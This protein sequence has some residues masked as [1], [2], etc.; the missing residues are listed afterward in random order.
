MDPNKNNNGDAVL[1]YGEQMLVKLLDQIW[2]VLLA[3]TLLAGTAS[4]FR[5]TST[6]WQPIYSLHIAL[7]IFYCGCFSLRKHLS[8]DVRVGIL[9]TLFYIVGISGVFSF[10]LVG[11]GAWWLVLCALIA[12]IFYSYRAGLIHAAISLVLIAVAGYAYTTGLLSIPFDANEY[13]TRVSTW[14]TLFFGCVFMSLFIFSAITTYQRALFSLLREFVHSKKE[15]EENLDELNKLRELIP[16]C[17]ECKNIRDDKGYWESVE[18]YMEKNSSLTF[19][20]CL[21]P[22]CGN[23]LY[24]DAWAKAMQSIKKPN[25]KA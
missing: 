1:I 24:G 14:A 25:L 18:A 10:G 19:T 12:K 9:I 21:C 16:I 3:V 2:Y 6:G 8:F 11:A 17:A 23:K 4:I 5:Y 15:L 22:S 20:H 7:A 13:I